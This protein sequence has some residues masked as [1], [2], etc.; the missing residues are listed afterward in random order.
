MV[1]PGMMPSL[2]S[3]P[4][5]LSWVMHQYHFPLQLVLASI[6][7]RTRARTCTKCFTLACLLSA[8]D[9]CSP[10]RLPPPVTHHQVTFVV[11]LCKMAHHHRDGRSLRNC[12]LQQREAPLRS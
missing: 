7:H 10:F 4:C 3:S 9:R 1:L 12:T 11:L 5:R 6:R 8:N 2:R